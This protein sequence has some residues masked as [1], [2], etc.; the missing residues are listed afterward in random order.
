MLYL[1]QANRITAWLNVSDMGAN[2]V[3]PEMTQSR[4]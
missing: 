4:F 1:L 3:F 2:S